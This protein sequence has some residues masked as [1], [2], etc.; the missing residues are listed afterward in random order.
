MSTFN[1][2]RRERN[3]AAA[4]GQKKHAVRSLAV[5]TESFAP[6]RSKLFAK[7]LELK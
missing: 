6:N 5:T 1:P 4:I 2:A 7:T 3:P